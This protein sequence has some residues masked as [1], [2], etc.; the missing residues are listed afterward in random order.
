MARIFIIEDDAPLREGLVRLLD[1]HGHECFCC[2]SF[3]DAADE[4]LA[5]NADCA[6]L[7]LS[8][9]GAFG[10]QICRDIRRDSDVPV[11]VVTSSDSEFD[12]VLS[13]DVGADDYVT[14]PYRP[15]ALLARIERALAR[16]QGAEAAAS[17]VLEV[18]GVSLDPSRGEV[19]F[20]NETCELTRNELRILHVLMQSAGEV[21]TRAELME[22]LWQTDSF[23]DDNTLTV[24]VNRLRRC[25]ENIGVPGGFV[26]TKRGQG[27]LVRP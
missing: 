26:E 6:L 27:Y 1:L 10:H 25:L 11:I 15:A 21:I 14:K 2:E 19:S 22:E 12:E 7:D 17:K 20:E 8:L 5:A 18:G 9:P 23:V 4:A 3:P 13:L 24:N 16:R